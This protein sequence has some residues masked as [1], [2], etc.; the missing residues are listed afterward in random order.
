M[1]RSDYGCARSSAPSVFP[2][3][4]K[5]FF[6]SFALYVF[7]E[8]YKR[9]LS[10][11]MVDSHRNDTGK[12]LLSFSKGTGNILLPL[13][14]QIHSTAHAP[15]IKMTTMPVLF[16][17]WGACSRRRVAVGFRPQRV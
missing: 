8:K 9:Y 7:I 1:S 3:C 4:I 14:Q 2:Y 6:P 5:A 15:S 11:A 16:V 17:T 10:G 12:T 13:W